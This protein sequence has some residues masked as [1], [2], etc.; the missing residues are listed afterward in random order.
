MKTIP[1]ILPIGNNSQF[2]H[3]EA[4]RLVY[5]KPAGTQLILKPTS[6]KLSELVKLT[7]LDLALKQ[8]VS[9]KKVYRRSHPRD[10]YMRE[11]I[12][13]KMGQ[14]F[15][16]YHPSEFEK[17]FINLL[18]PD[19]YYQ[20][21]PYVK[22]L[23]EEIRIQKKSF[24]EQ[25]INDLEIK[26]L[27]RKDLAF[28]ISL[29]VRNTKGKQVKNEINH[30]LNEVDKHIG[31]LVTHK[32]EEAMQLLSMLQGNIF[33]LKNLDFELAE[34]IQNLI[35]HSSPTYQWAWSDVFLDFAL[36]GFDVF[37]EIGD[38][39][40]DMGSDFGLDGGDFDASG[41]D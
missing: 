25:I 40:D 41:F 11:Y 2:E 7:F 36:E 29:Y 38:V 3:S 1:E 8:V 13:V 32:P 20:L 37:S 27:F 28:I 24:K 19:S 21:K 14:N 26:N 22:E 15:E 17:A 33:L 39:F 9:V 6:T 5:L 34:S 31:D 16:N 10:P 35:K 18:D 30:F 12:H 4:S 23:A